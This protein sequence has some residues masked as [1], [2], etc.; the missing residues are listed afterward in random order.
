MLKNKKSYKKELLKEVQ[1]IQAESQGSLKKFLAIM[2]EDSFLDEE[3]DEGQGA[4]KLSSLAAI[5]RLTMQM[6]V[7]DKKL[8]KLISESQR[9]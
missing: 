7:I 6:Q 2:V 9:S 4:T 3:D 5:T 8:N 1:K